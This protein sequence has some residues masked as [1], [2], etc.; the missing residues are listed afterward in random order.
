MQAELIPKAALAAAV[1]SGKAEAMHRGQTIAVMLRMPIYTLAKIDAFAAQSGKKRGGVINMLCEV[2]IEAVQEHMSPEVGEQLV[3][4]ESEAWT[5]LAA[6][7]EGKQSSDEQ[8][9]Y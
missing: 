7:V 6:V 8:E 1:L 9:V 3:Q 2:G 5:K 4:L